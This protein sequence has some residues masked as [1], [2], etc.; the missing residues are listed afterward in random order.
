MTIYK[1]PRNYSFSH[2]FTIFFLQP[3][4]HSN[5]ET[6]VVAMS[7]K[8]QQREL[9]VGRLMWR[10]FGPMIDG[11]WDTFIILDSSFSLIMEQTDRQTDMWE[12]LKQ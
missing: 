7:I 10:Q 3:Q 8:W 11:S 1:F 5:R 4:L 9:T 12:Y 6:S 2:T